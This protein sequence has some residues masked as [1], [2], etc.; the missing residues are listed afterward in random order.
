MKRLRLLLTALCLCAGALRA[1]DRPNVLV[2]L[3]DD[4]GYE[5]IG[6]DGGKSY[7]T[8]VIDGLAANGMR[9]THCYAQPNCTPTRAQLMSGQSN[10]RNYVKF[11]YLDPAVKTFGN[12]FKEAGYSTCIVGK[13]QLGH[14]KTDLPQPCGFDEHCLH[15]YLHVGGKERYANPGMTY[16]GEVREFKN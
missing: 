1:A 3:V 16:N 11:G 13:W 15:H 6:A 14:D 9:F 10:V 5:C 12:F 7:Q 2:I 4:L 8:P